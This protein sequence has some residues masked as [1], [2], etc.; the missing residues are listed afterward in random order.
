MHN[1]LSLHASSHSQPKELKNGGRI[2][3]KTFAVASTLSNLQCISA[4]TVSCCIGRL[5][6]T[7]RTAVSNKVDRFRLGVK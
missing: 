5:H 4:H 6:T 2:Q 3:N 1:H 7:Y